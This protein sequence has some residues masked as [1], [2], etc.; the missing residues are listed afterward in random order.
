MIFSSSTELPF[1]NATYDGEWKEGKMDGIGTV[2]FSSSIEHDF[3]GCR[4]KGDFK[5]NN[6][7]GEGQYVWGDG[8]EYYGMC[9]N[10]LISRVL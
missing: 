8:R 10:N 9:F 2:I 4:F 1:S 5:D 3:Q 7:D 6:M